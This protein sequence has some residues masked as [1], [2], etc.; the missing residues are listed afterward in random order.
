MIIDAHT[1][2]HTYEMKGI[3]VSEEE[4]IEILDKCDIDKAM[5]CCPFYLLSDFKFGNDKVLKFMNKYPNRII[6]FATINPLFENEAIEEIK[7]CVESG[8]KGIK[9]HCDLSQVPYNDYLTFPI[10]EE[11]IKFDIPVFIHTSEDNISEAEFISQK[12]PECTFIFAHIGNKLWKKTCKFAK[13]QKNVIL[14][15]SGLIFEIGFLEE[16]VENV[17]DERVV[18]GSDFVFV[19]LSINLGI[20]KC[21]SLS[22]ESKNKILGL[23]MKRILKL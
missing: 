1:C 18:F 14:C 20:V 7:R 13:F 17:G 19:N 10:I 3:R 8:M 12:Y 5:V 6:G 9:L 16:A 21:S 4:F 11:A 2:W 15:I 23:N 22:K